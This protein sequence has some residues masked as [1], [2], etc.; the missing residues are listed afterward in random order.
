ML[1]GLSRAIFPIGEGCERFNRFFEQVFSN[2]QLRQ[3]FGELFEFRMRR[4]LR[5]DISIQMSLI[6][7]GGPSQ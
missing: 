1:K 3:L 2:P 4:V 6:V 5:I 7:H